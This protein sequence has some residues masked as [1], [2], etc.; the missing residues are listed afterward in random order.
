M[1]VKLEHSTGRSF[2][3]NHCS[4]RLKIHSAVMNA[5]QIEKKH[6]LI[7]HFCRNL[8]KSPILPHHVPTTSHLSQIVT[9]FFE[10]FY[11]NGRL[12]LLYYS[13]FKANITIW[14]Q[15]TN[16]HVIKV[17]AWPAF[18]EKKCLFAGNFWDEMKVATHLQAK[19]RNSMLHA[20][21][22]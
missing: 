16:K 10:K 6:S 2:W 12:K 19:R 3:F 5:N 13:I 17:S 22:I 9:C 15:C 21:K 4:L 11:K 7:S 1:L 8:T 20:W 14:I 18:L